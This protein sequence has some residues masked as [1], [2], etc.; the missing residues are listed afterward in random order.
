MILCSTCKHRRAATYDPNAPDVGYAD[1]VLGTARCGHPEM[2]RPTG[3]DPVSGTRA[4]Y[5][6]DHAGRRRYG[7][8]DQP[9][10]RDVN[11]GDCPMHEG[12]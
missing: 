8:Y 10:C 5:V 2:V 11:F 3:V 1:R 12:S 9:N 6:Q 4:H 7:A